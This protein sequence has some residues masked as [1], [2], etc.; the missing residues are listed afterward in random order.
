MS[1]RHF[2]NTLHTF[3]VLPGIALLFLFL[4]I[5]LFLL[6]HNTFAA[7]STI[8]INEILYDPKGTNTGY[9]WIELKNIK[10][11]AIDIGGW[12]IK[13]AGTAFT[14]KATLPPFI[15]EPGSIVLIGEPKVPS[16]HI[17]L[18]SLAFQNGGAETDGVQI[19]NSQGIVVDTL[20]YDSPNTNNLPDDI[21]SPSSDTAPDVAS[22]HTL[23]RISPVDTDSSSADFV[24]CENPTPGEENFFPPTAVISIPPI[25]YIGQEITLDG[26]DSFDPDTPSV[27]DPFALQTLVFEWT[28]SKESIPIFSTSGATSTYTFENAGIF[29]ISLTVTD[30]T[31]LSHT[32]QSEITVS[33]DP[34]NP[35]ITAIAEC[36]TLPVGSIVTIEGIIT[37]APGVLYTSD[38]YI[39]DETGGI[40]I[41]VLP[42]MNLQLSSIY[43]VTGTV[44]SV[45]GETRLNLKS[46]IFVAES[47]A[48][49]PAN[50][51]QEDLTH[52]IG[53]LITIELGIKSKRG[54]ILDGFEETTE[55]L[56]PIYISDLT[57]I[58]LSNIGAGT[59]LLITG[60]ISQYGTNDDGSPKI[61]IMPRFESDLTIIETNTLAQTGSPLSALLWAMYTFPIALLIKRQLRYFS[62]N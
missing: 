37:S 20:L 19:L 25:A 31:G 41:K 55:S 56:T 44:S 3:K 12:T 42:E 51:H 11:E 45:Y 60:I 6:P 38:A 23:S 36:R 5:F 7:S 22:G 30:S 57:G 46:S 62:L 4:S 16:A 39:Q 49:T 2:S 48:V 34:A 14:H 47:E 50:A 17:T 61:R 15:V 29:T 59:T 27:P 53:S 9:E 24:D 58:S 52:L 26:T 1:T 32:S 33:E 10:S 13:I 43:R 21:S 28:I 18:P 8:L 35:H 54:K 40:R